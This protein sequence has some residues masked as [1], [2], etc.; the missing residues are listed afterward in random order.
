MGSFSQNKK[1]AD[2]PC[3]EEVN[4]AAKIRF[5]KNQKGR[6]QTLQKSGRLTEFWTKPNPTSTLLLSI[7]IKCLTFIFLL[8][9]LG[10]PLMFLSISYVLFVL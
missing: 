1:T 10:F 7:V 6:S 8:K 5:F 9:K 2:Q 4:K 3:S